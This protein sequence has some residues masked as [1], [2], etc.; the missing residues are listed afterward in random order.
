VADG[1]AS[2]SSTDVTASLAYLTG[3]G[4]TACYRIFPPSSGRPPDSPELG[5]FDMRIADCRPIASELD[6]DR[7]GFVL[8]AHTTAF[9]EMLDPE[10]VK[11]AYYP[12]MGQWL[13]G[14]VGAEAVVVFDHNVRS[15]AGPARG[16]AGV[17]APVDAVHDDYTEA[18]G[19][20]RAAE[21]LDAHGLGHL[22]G[23]RVAMINVWRPLH[24][25][26]LDLP[27]TLCLAPSVAPGDLVS[28][29]IHH[30]MEDRLDVPSHSGEIYSAR[31]NP[32]HRWF[33]VSAM[34]PDEVLVFK[35][36]DSRTDVA[37]YVPHTAFAHPGRPAQFTPRESIEV[38]TVVVY[39]ERA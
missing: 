37:R 32:A 21:L 1:N 24:G 23:R 35:G 39:P 7:Q 16:Q 3:V 5:R 30:Y 33:Y 17:R 10:R 38:R 15:A 28:T 6:L 29:P 2:S 9:A 12:E 20:K 14:I 4:D 8:R 22:K 27:L 19:P 36:Y 18:S 13:R 31:H 25:P 11:A 26:V 34:Q